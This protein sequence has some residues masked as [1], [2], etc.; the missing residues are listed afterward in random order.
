MISCSVIVP[1]CNRLEDLKRCLQSLTE[2]DIRE[3]DWEILLVDN[4]STD[5]TG[6]WCQEQVGGLSPRIRYVWEPMPGLLSGRHRGASEAEGQILSFV[7]DDIEASSGWLRAICASFADEEVQLVG[8]PCLPHYHAQPPEWM[9][10]FWSATPY[11]GRSCSWL[12]LL[13]LGNERL[14]VSP[15][16]IW[17]LNFSIRKQMLLNLGGF[18]P[19]CIPAS[20]QRYQG[21]GETGLA[22]KAELRGCRS[23]YDPGVRV[24]HKVSVDR[25]TIEYF[26]RRA[27]YQGVCDSY[28]KAR[29]LHGL[30]P[31]S[32]QNRTWARSQLGALK[33]AVLSR[34][35]AGRQENDKSPMSEAKRRTRDAY[36]R[37]FSFHQEAMR[38]DPGVLAWVRRRDY[39]DYSLPVS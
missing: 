20:L 31:G 13:D 32:G 15:L 29:R 36:E 30:Y 12:S 11:G 17:G 33:R 37:G 23:V 1:T 4:S 25:M 38:S 16:Y 7:D 26:E 6:T 8:G 21:D 3:V 9:E 5:G 22:V 2:Q 27:F 28:T 14:S 34:I 18:H 35:A 10:A 19:D 39:W 24:F